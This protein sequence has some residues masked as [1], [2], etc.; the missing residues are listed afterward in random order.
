GEEGAVG[1][2]AH[3]RPS[4][5]PRA[6]GGEDGSHQKDTKDT[7]K[8][9]RDSRSLGIWAAGH[10]WRIPPVH[11]DCPRRPDLQSPS[12][13]WAASR[14]DP[15]RQPWRF[16]TRSIAERA[17]STFAGVLVCPI[18]PRRQTRP[19]TS[20]RP[21]PIS[22]LNSRSSAPRAAASSVPSGIQTVVSEG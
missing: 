12:A 4:P 8:D 7:K 19:R 5:T 3:H 13:P 21:P 16:S 11:N 14:P 1:V 20:P 22:R 10:L 2:H 18:R 15:T 6:R 17:N 9:G